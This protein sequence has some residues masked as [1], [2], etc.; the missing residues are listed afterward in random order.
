M[1]HSEGM[2]L[3]FI[4]GFCGCLMFAV[5]VVIVTIAIAK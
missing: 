4:L 3:A 2:V 1:R 5:L